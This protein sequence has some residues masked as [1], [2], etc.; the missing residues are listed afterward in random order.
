MSNAAAALEALKV[1]DQPFI[2]PAQAAP[3]IGCDPLYIRIA[4]RDCPEKLGFPILRCGNRTKIPRLPFIRFV[5]E[6]R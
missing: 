2:T 1:N 6:G 3:V 4:A 5:E